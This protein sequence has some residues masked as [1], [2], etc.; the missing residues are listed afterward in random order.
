MTSN[1]DNLR[2]IR[3]AAKGILL[4][5]RALLTQ[6]MSITQAAINALEVDGQTI[7]DLAQELKIEEH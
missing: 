5:T 3:D 1:L 4:L 6:G 2:D 7:S